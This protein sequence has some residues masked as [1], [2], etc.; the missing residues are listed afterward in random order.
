MN[1][2]ILLWEVVTPRRASRSTKAVY[3]SRRC[4]RGAMLGAAAASGLRVGM[5]GGAMNEDRQEL[6][7][8]DTTRR[9][10]GWLVWGWS[11]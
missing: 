5:E 3:N 11:A 1:S 9:Y 2:M 8:E 6:E 10:M 7:A 4:G